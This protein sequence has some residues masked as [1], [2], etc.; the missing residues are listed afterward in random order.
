VS[1]RAVRIRG[2]AHPPLHEVGEDPDPR[3]TFANERTFLAWNRTALALIGGGLAA[4][5]LL[6]FESDAVRI[7]VGLAPVLLGGVLAGT[8][9][10]RWEANER[11]MRLREPL[12]SAAPPRWLSIALVGIAIVVAVLVVVDAH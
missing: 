7:I 2:M 6:D 10:R 12:P 8:S 11:A 9:Y 5:Q 1:G 4:A 3:L